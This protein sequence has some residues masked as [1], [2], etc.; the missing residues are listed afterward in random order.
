MLAFWFESGLVLSAY[1]FLAEELGISATQYRPLSYLLQL[2]FVVKLFSF[3]KWITSCFCVHRYFFKM[4]CIFCNQ[5]YRSQE[6]KDRCMYVW[7]CTKGNLSCN[8][9]CYNVQ[10]V[11]I[12]FDWGNFYA[13]W[14]ICFSHLHF[15]SLPFLCHPRSFLYV[16]SAF[17]SLL[18]LKQ[19]AHVQP[20]SLC[21][22]S[23]Q[24]YGSSWW[25]RYGASTKLKLYG[26]MKPSGL[27]LHSCFSLK[28]LYLI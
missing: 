13:E 8:L 16:N 27:V 9:T 12:V 6:L 17:L 26:V 4:A 2:V 11:C 19:L 10:Y 21:Y 25:S 14:N 28:S 24:L 3:L 18:K 7:I 5:M 22:D 23:I 20:C 15:W 1:L